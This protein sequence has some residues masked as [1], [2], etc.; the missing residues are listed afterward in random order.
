MVHSAR[1][2]SI[3]NAPNE[4]MVRGH[5]KRGGFPANS[6]ARVMSVLR[7]GTRQAALSESR[8]KV[9]Y[10]AA[11]SASLTIFVIPSRSSVITQTSLPRA[12]P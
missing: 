5:A 8:E 2:R 6:V 1:P 9:F 12:A 7:P 3:Y 11:L 10:F 4:E